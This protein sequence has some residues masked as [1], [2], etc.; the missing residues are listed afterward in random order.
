MTTA[1]VVLR[2]DVFLVAGGVRCHD[3]GEPIV[4]GQGMVADEV[5]WDSRICYAIRHR[6]ACPEPEPQG[7]LL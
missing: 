4:F 2:T 6:R 7:V 1:A 5:E 3:C